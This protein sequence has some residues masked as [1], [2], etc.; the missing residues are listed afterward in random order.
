MSCDVL[1]MSFDVRCLCSNTQ[2]TDVGGGG[3]ES[4]SG[5]L[6]ARKLKIRNSQ[7][8]LLDDKPSNGAVMR[9]ATSAEDLHVLALQDS[10]KV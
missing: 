4:P 1:V 3:G 2:S 9:P 5:P 8:N 7:E 6:K 10:P